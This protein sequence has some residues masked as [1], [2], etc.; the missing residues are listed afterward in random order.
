MLDRP[1]GFA[2]GE[3]EFRGGRD[4]SKRLLAKGPADALVAFVGHNCVKFKLITT[5][6]DA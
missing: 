5:P 4:R 2:I 1:I 6:T 3:F